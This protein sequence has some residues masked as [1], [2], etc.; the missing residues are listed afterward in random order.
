MGLLPDDM[1]LG[2]APSP[3]HMH[4]WCDG[5]VLSGLAGYDGQSSF[6]KDGRANS[7]NAWPKLAEI[8]P[9]P[10]EFGSNLS[11]IEQVWPATFLECVQIRGNF[12]QNWG[13][14]H[15]QQPDLSQTRPSL[16]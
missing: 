2:R 5:S 16:G 10:A 11:V 15:R 14:L 6:R 7:R 12:G 3:T 13:T 1:R 9:A 4:T 8:E